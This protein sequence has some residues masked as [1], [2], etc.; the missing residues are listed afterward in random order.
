MFLFRVQWIKNSQ[1]IA[2][3]NT[4]RMSG[5]VLKLVYLRE[6]LKAIEGTDSCRSR[7]A[8]LEAG[9]FGWR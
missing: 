9:T 8:W 5:P 6:R 2:K 4:P 3:H 7:V 1:R